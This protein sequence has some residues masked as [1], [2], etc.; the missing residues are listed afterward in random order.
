MSDPTNAVTPASKATLENTVGAATVVAY[1]D[2]PDD[3]VAQAAYAT[4][5]VAGF[6][7]RGPEHSFRLMDA[8]SE[9]HIALLVG[10]P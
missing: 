1:D 9:G 8:V 7:P 2:A 3:P 6:V 10:N 4:G 5:L